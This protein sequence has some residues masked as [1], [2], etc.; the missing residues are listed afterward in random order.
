[1]QFVAEKLGEA[2]H[3]LSTRRAVQLARNVEAVAAVLATEGG[4]PGTEDAFF[5]ALRH[6]LPD[7]AW[8]RPV[9]RTQLSAIHR[10]AWE[11]VGVEI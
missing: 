6:S 3:P 8:G 11:I 9:L 7:A 2:G 10:T 5:V 1:M 4:T